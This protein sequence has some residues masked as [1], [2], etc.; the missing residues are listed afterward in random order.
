MRPPCEVVVKEVLPAIRAMLVKELVERHRLS[1]VEVA[2]KL[3]ITQPAVSQYLRMLRGAGRGSALFKNIKKHVRELADD[4][5]RGKLKRKQIIERYC[6]ICRSMGQRE[7]ICLLH[8]RA[9]P[10]LKREGCKI[11]LLR[12]RS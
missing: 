2:R 9:A 7:I 8:M 12:D 10:Y 11:C 4:I 6:M 3:G 5:A 1:Q